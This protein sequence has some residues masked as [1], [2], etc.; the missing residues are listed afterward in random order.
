VQR[1]RAVG[2]GDFLAEFSPDRDRWLA[3]AR[4]RFVADLQLDSRSAARRRREY[5]RRLRRF[6]YSGSAAVMLEGVVERKSWLH[7]AMSDLMVL[8]WHGESEFAA[9]T[10][11]MYDLARL[12]QQ[13]A[14]DD[15]RLPDDGSVRI[16][17]ACA[18]V[19]D[20]SDDNDR[21]ERRCLR[22]LVGEI[23]AAPIDRP[24]AQR[25]AYFNRADNTPGGL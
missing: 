7:E 15:A 22:Q 10:A 5:N 16:A 9:R 6:L 17:F 11:A 4:I 12:E 2:N 20:D 24:L 19:N 14:E 1:G 23:V 8:I 18:E 25:A 21:G 13:L 3:L